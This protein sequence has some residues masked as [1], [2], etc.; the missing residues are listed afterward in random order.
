MIYKIVI[1]D[2]AKFE[3]KE[4]FNWY[5][6]IHPNLAKK[7]LSSFKTSLKLIKNNPLLFQIRYDDVRVIM[8]DVFPYLIHFRIINNQIIIQSI[9]HTARDSKLSIL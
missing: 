9:V 8:L 7:F 1:I 4:S 3:Y 6:N 5:K 2:E